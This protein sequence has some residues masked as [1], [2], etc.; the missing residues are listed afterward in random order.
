M[1][2]DELYTASRRI[3]S[4][5][6][7]LYSMTMYGESSKWPTACRIR[8][9]KKLRFV[10]SLLIVPHAICRFHCDA[11][12]FAAENKPT[13]RDKSPKCFSREPS[14][15]SLSLP[16]DLMTSRREKI[17]IYENTPIF[18]SD[19]MLGIVSYNSLLVMYVKTSWTK[20][21]IWGWSSA[22]WHVRTF[23]KP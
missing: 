8:S 16:F 14:S 21:I 22:I 20:R 23:P 6:I 3:L 9:F 11:L 2:V 15:V 12:L 10:T 13:Q 5:T 7:L 19:T 17:C 1:N 4:S 18:I